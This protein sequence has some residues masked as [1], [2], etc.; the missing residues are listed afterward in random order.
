MIGIDFAAGRR[1][2]FEHALYLHAQVPIILVDLLALVLRY[3][4]LPALL[5][6]PLGHDADPLE[7]VVES[8]KRYKRKG[9]TYRKHVKGVNDETI[10]FGGLQDLV[11]VGGASEE[12]REPLLKLVEDVQTFQVDGWL[13]VEML[14]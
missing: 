4:Q 7:L 8:L 6:V 13:L 9:G 1:I 2:I 10:F 3:L 11:D 12:V 5:G 14:C